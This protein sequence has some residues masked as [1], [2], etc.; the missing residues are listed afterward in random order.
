[1]STSS[2]IAAN[3]Q[4]Y[5]SYGSRTNKFLLIWYGFCYPDNLHDS[6]TLRL[7]VQFTSSLRPASEVVIDSYVGGQG[8]SFK[9]N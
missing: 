8:L 4:V 9:K 1:M 6:V 2:P 5:N 7:H 3:K